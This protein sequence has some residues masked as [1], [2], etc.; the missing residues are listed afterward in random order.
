MLNRVI[1]KGTLKCHQYWPGGQGE[2]VQCEAA[3]LRV[4]NIGTVPGDHYSVSTLRWPDG[5][6][7][8]QGTV[9]DGLNTIWMVASLEL[10]CFHPVGHIMVSFLPFASHSLYATLTVCTIFVHINN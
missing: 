5:T 10:I 4:A 2:E 7:S 3:G 9:V 1:E 6:C 8:V